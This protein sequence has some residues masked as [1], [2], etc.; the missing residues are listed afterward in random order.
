MLI[1]ILRARFP[2]VYRC[3]FNKIKIDKIGFNLF[4]KIDMLDKI[5]LYQVRHI[6]ILRRKQLCIFEKKKKKKVFRVYQCITTYFMSYL[7]Q[8]TI[9]LVNYNM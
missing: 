9:Q 3:R 1:Y 7:K 5:G 4:Y 2:N 8:K 6:D